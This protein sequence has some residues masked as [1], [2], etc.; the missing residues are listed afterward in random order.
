MMAPMMVICPLDA[1]IPPNGII[2]S[3]GIGG[4]R[5]SKKHATNSQKYPNCQTKS[6][7]VLA[8]LANIIEGWVK[9]LS[10]PLG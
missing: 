10:S 6:M 8:R 9:A 4:N 2:N 7:R 3:L 1:K 5:F